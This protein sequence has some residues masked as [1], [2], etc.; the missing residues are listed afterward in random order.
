MVDGQGTR[1]MLGRRILVGL[2]L[3]VC[4]ILGVAYAARYGFAGAE[5]VL[6][7]VVMALVVASTIGAV[8]GTRNAAVR[9]AMLPFDVALVVAVVGSV[10]APF[11]SEVD[12]TTDRAII[13][14]FVGAGAALVASFVAM[15][16]AG[17]RGQSAGLLAVAI[18]AI[19]MVLAAP[20]LVDWWGGRV[21]SGSTP[22]GRDPYSPQASAVLFLGRGVDGM[23]LTSDLDPIVGGGAVPVP[24]NATA[25]V[26][27]PLSVSGPRAE[28]VAG[29]RPDFVVDPHGALTLRVPRHLLDRAGGR[30]VVEVHDGNCGDEPVEP[31][32]L[33]QRWY[34][35]HPSAA[36]RVELH[37]DRLSL[38]DVLPR[39]SLDVVIGTGARLAPVTCVDLT[40]W[41][42]VA[43]ARDGGA[44]FFAGCVDPL[45]LREDELAAM[46]PDAFQDGGCAR[47]YRRFAAI[48][49]GFAYDKVPDARSVRACLARASVRAELVVLRHGDGAVVAPTLVGH[50]GEHAAV[51][52]C[53]APH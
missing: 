29:D 15:V 34:P 16:L 39:R 48:A 7:L 40:D 43:I 3:L 18:G 46:T 52:R 2:A 32:A 11:G 1:W 24:V 31:G 28:S 27:G 12:T 51:G 25:W 21:D 41:R 49:S 33:V 13:S 10:L 19:V 36:G 14:V 20:T 17:R 23:R 4:W 35:S 22:L 47:R 42:T 26:G 53:V 50:Q 30:V 8:W 6:V 45:H 37:V 38:R 5:G 44:R 9:R